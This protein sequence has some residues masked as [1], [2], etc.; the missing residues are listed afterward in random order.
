MLPIN[1]L[2]TALFLFIAIVA[3]LS[4]VLFI[5]ITKCHVPL[6]RLFIMPIVFCLPLLNATLLGTIF[7]SGSF[8]N[9]SLSDIF[10]VPAFFYVCHDKFLRS[11]N[12]NLPM[13]WLFWIYFLWIIL[14]LYVGTHKYDLQFFTLPNVVAVIKFPTL[15]AYFYVF[16]HFVK[17]D[18]DLKTYVTAWG[19]S[20]CIVAMMGIAGSLL[21]LFFRIDTPFAGHFRALGTFGNPNMFAGY[22]TMTFCL[23]FIYLAL[24]G[25]RWLFMIII[26]LSVLSVV[27]AASK[28]AFIAFF[29]AFMVIGLLFP[30]FRFKFIV[31][32]A[33]AM[34]VLISTFFLDS[35]IQIYSKRLFDIE[36]GIATSFDTRTYLWGESLKVW[37]ENFLCGVGKDNL[38]KVLTGATEELGEISQGKNKDNSGKDT[39]VQLVSHST[40]IGLLCEMGT[41]GLILFLAL[42]AVF[43]ARLIST[44]IMLNPYSNAYLIMV[45]MLAAL[46]GVMTQGGVTNVEDSRS[47][48]MLLGLIYSVSE[49]IRSQEF[50]KTMLKPSSSV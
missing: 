20:A 34:A 41:I 50:D 9:I 6:N 43:L 42:L 38:V 35:T 27:M 30:R 33:A 25:K 23:S 5:F 26:L 45:S 40:Y 36:G 47:F 17:N 31:T 24:G 1:D 2:V 21:Y 8:V 7:K 19:L 4:V 13:F 14:S 39:K 48:W 3:P 16:E 37:E 12:F 15:L 29:C 28:G 22:M 46:V 11:R 49:R 10:L 44:I 32:G 18:A